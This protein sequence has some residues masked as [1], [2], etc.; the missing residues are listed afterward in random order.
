MYLHT[1]ELPPTRDAG[2]FTVFPIGDL[3]CDQKAFAEKRFLAYRK[4]ILATRPAVA[5]FVGDAIEGHL[6]DHRHF[7]PDAIRRDFLA[8]M[9]EYIHACLQYLQSLFLPITTAGIPL[10]IVEGNH[11]RFP[12]FVGFSAMLADR[13]RG[14][15]LGGEGFVNIYSGRPGQ[16]ART[17]LY[18]AHGYGGGRKDGASVNAMRE[19]MTS[20]KA[21][22]YIAGHVHKSHTQIIP[23][24][25]ANERGTAITKRHVAL[26]RTPSFIERGIPGVV[27]YAGRKGYPT[28]DESIVAVRVDPTHGRMLRLDLP[29]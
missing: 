28:S 12:A 17:V 15:Y 6:P 20:F 18:C 21:D 19:Y 25:G 29:I 9:D 24:L 10:V 7:N 4:H 11:D 26:I 22:L 2:W 16:R 8:R 1:I 27:T 5:V 23:L 3:H 13:V 14:I